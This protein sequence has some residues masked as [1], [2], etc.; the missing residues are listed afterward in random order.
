M[1]EIMC[2]STFSAVWALGAIVE[3]K[4]YSSVGFAATSPNLGEELQREA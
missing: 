1:Q 3:F 4:F 2:A